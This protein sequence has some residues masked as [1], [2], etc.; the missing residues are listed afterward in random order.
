MSDAMSCLLSGK[1]GDNDVSKEER[2]NL[3]LPDDG[4]WP[5]PSTSDIA[6]NLT[7]GS[8]LHSGTMSAS[9][10]SDQVQVLLHIAIL[11]K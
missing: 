8:G 5:F 2:S 3:C 10:C 1:E 11:I 4:M 9:T 6:Q 7:E